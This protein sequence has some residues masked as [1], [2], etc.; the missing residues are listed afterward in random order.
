MRVN[1]R[2]NSGRFS[3]MPGFSNQVPDGL[4]R[5]DVTPS[6]WSATVVLTSTSTPEPAAVQHPP[7]TLRQACWRLEPHVQW[8]FE[9]IIQSDE[10]VAV[11]QSIVDGTALGISDGSYKNGRCTSAALIEGPS[12]SH[13]RILAVNRVPGHPSIQSSY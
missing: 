5:V 8:T 6:R 7:T 2:L 12:K 13:G 1:R 9:K 10:G 4:S 11:A 3:P